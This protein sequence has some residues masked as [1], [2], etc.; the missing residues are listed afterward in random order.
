[1]KSALVCGAGG[2]IGGHLIKRLKAEGYWVRGVDLKHMKMSRPK[3][4]TSSSAICATNIFVACASIGASTKS[5]SWLPTW[6]APGISSPVN[7]TPTS[8]TIRRQ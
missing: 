5:I 8:C 4:T 7:T 3:R 1:M 6:G 2:F